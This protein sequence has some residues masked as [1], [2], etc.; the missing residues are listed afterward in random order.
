MPRTISD[1]FNDFHSALTPSETESSA[2]TTHRASIEAC[3]KSNFTLNNFY[4]IGSFGNGTS[5]S[6]HSDVD[7]I[8]SLKGDVLRENS[9]NTLTRVRDALD[10]RFPNTNVHISSPAVVVPFGY[11]G[12]E[13]TEIVPADYTRVTADGYKVYDIPDTQGGWTKSSPDAHNAYVRN[14]NK[15]LG[16]KVKPLIRFI[17]AWKYFNNVEISSFYL[18]M[19]VAKYASAETTISYA[20]DIK[21]IFSLLCENQFA[22]LQDPMGISG[23]IVPTFS[24]SKLTDAQSKA[25]TA[26][27]RAQK[28]LDAEKA[29]NISDAFYWWNLL[30]NGEFPS[31]YY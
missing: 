19:R 7:Y 29:G 11:N 13:T 25:A 12:K 10:Q 14:V 31:Y 15:N 2:S 23:Y 6:G 1:G 30:F 22:S 4:R 3:L 18:E 28:A 26:L 27:S 16:L 20:I 17:K 24:T 9:A 5:I 21:R 8:A